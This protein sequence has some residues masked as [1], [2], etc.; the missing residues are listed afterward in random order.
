MNKSLSVLLMT[1]KAWIGRNVAPALGLYRLKNCLTKS[2]FR[3][4]ILDFDIRSEDDY[5]KRISLGEYDVIGMSATHDNMSADLDTLWRF[6]VESAKTGKRCIFVAGGQQPSLNYKQW[7]LSGAVDMVF[8]GFAE[9]ALDSF[10]RRLSQLRNKVDFTL[11][12]AAEGINGIAFIDRGGKAVCKPSPV[13]TQEKFRKL[14]F[15]NIM[16]SDIPYKEYW[17]IAR[18]QRINVFNNAEFVVETVR[19]YTTSHCPRRCGFCSSQSFLPQSQDKASTIYMLSADE[20][21]ELVLNCIDR[22]GAM[23][24]LFNDDDFPVG[25]QAGIE[26]ISRFC[27]L[28]IDA[29]K[30]GRVPKEMKFFCQARVADFI[31]RDRT[32]REDL[33]SLMKKAGFHNIGLGVETFSER[34]MCLP[35]INKMGINVSDCRRV[36][37]SLLKSGFVTQLFLILGIPDSTLDDLLKTMRVAADYICKGADI[38]VVPKMYAYP[39]SPISVSGDYPVCIRE[40]KNPYN[41]RVTEIADYF[42]PHDKTITLV[43]DRVKSVTEEVVEE[44]KKERGWDKSLIPG[45]LVGLA[46]F[47]AIARLIDRKDMA[48]DFKGVMNLMLDREAR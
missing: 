7:L 10:C 14:S 28:I 18:R 21:F 20:V 15:L 9:E 8:L 11:E 4:D 32:V 43:I 5:L 22:Y 44:I 16:D 17:D 23:G 39:G 36:I 19:L 12:D 13:L 46:I 25:N 45:S 31:D 42:I 27:G 34:L 30:E 48:D 29:K 2:G 35:S 3:C 47:I 41:G 33:I 26:R 6:R 38:A 40:W 1:S 24:V 37:D